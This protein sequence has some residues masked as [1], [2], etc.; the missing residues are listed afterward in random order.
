[1]AASM[2]LDA[3]PFTPIYLPGSAWPATNWWTN[4][5]Y[6]DAVASRQAWQAVNEMGVR[7]S[8][9]FWLITDWGVAYATNA[10][11]A[12]TN[13]SDWLLITNRAGSN[14]A[15]AT[16]ALEGGAGV[17]GIDGI[18]GID[19]I[20]GTNGLDGMNGL[21]GTNGVNGV[22]TNVPV[23]VAGANIIIV[24]NGVTNTISAVLNDT[25]LITILTNFLA[26]YN[27]SITN[28]TTYTL[29]ITNDVLTNSINNLNPAV[30]A[31]PWLG[32][33]FVVTRWLAV[34]D[35]SLEGLYGTL[36]ASDG[37]FKTDGGIVM[38]DTGQI[39]AGP[40]G[41][42]TQFGNI[43]LSGI[44]GSATFGNPSNPHLA[45]GTAGELTAEQYRF[46]TIAA[47]TNV[48]IGTTA[49]GFWA[50]VYDASGT[51]MGWTPVYTNR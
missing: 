50:Q 12:C 1:M 10:A 36:F 47:P 3:Q 25:N 38:D 26:T 23:L 24:V 8:N 35:G 5:P 41:F 4:S 17:N 32:G 28:I 9:T 30:G 51:A 27:I 39:T 2:F 18:D 45:I 21:P 20:P 34:G 7:A 13:I 29:S 49:P 16:G 46:P 19:G 42:N 22:A 43:H 6:P 15:L 31:P 37:T 11:P 44:D 33:N 48:T 40:G 14:Y